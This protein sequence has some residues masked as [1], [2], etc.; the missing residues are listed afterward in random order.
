VNLALP[1]DFDDYA[2]E[3]EAKGVFWDA[4][5]TTDGEALAVVFYD[6]ARLAQDVAEELDHEGICALRR[7]IVIPRLTREAMVDAARRLPQD[8]W[9]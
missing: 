6:P 2:W 8:F 7:V 3:V 5:I 4:R 1:D 9:D